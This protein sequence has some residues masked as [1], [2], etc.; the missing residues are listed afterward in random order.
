MRP[1]RLNEL[2]ATAR[3]IKPL[4]L[5]VYFML[6]EMLDDIERLEKGRL[7]RNSALSQMG[8]ALTFY[9]NRRHLKLDA[10]AIGD[11]EINWQC[12]GGIGYPYLTASEHGYVAREALRLLAGGRDE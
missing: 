9:A 5:E 3:L 6:T 10:E 12:H 4:H 2:R 1:E 8:E 11:M 7:R